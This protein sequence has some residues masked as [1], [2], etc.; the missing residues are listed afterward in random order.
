MIL[1]VIFYGYEIWFL[2]L[3]HWFAE[4]GAQSPGGMDSFGG[5]KLYIKI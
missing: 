2:T 1:P 4:C 3:W 5:G